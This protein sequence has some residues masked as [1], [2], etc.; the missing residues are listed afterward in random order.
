MNQDCVFDVATTGEEEFAKGYEFA[1]RLKKSSVSVRVH[2]N[3]VCKDG[4]RG[5]MVVVLPLSSSAPT[6]KGK[7]TFNVEGGNKHTL[8]LD[9]NGRACLPLNELG[10]GDHNVSVTFEGEEGSDYLPAESPTVVQQGEPKKPPG[11]T[12]RYWWLIVLLILLVLLIIW[13]A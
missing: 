6:P 5:I 8:T 9:Q 10:K 4:S 1:Q 13:L 11:F 2:G 3:H 12:G 7:V